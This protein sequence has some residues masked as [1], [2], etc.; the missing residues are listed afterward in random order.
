MPNFFP[1]AAAVREIALHAGSLIM[2]YYTGQKSLDVTRKEDASPVTA[3]DIAANTYI[4][5]A[6]QALTPDIP[7]IAEESENSDVAGDSFWL[8]DPLD[9]TKSF[10]RKSGEFTVNI[11]LV[12]NKLP[13]FG[14]ID[15][16][17][18][19]Y[20]YY[21]DEAGIPYKQP[22][23][24]QAI[25]ITARLPSPEGVDVVASQS[26]RTPETDQYIHT[27]PVRTIVPAASSLKFCRVAEGSADIYPRFGPTMEWDTA[28]GH[29]LLLA[30]GGSVKMLDG[31]PFMYGKPGFL[32][33]SFIARGK[34]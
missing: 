11:A 10:I 5:E 18:A 25:Q 34:E 30:A 32:N 27:L 33:P 24:G 28:A 21:M 9:G 4:V 17:A 14:V 15:I 22:H 20:C 1:Y 23:E 29:A 19:G 31:Q 2:E 8:V 16:P 12:Q 3:A 7:I 6:L 13:V 26:H